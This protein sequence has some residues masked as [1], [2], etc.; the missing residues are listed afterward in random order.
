MSENQF[1]LT[2]QKGPQPGKVY[3][4]LT[5]AVTI[6]RDPMADIS[7][8]DP[9][10]SRQH[11]RLTRTASGYVVE[12]MGSTNGT[13][14]DGEKLDADTPLS[15]T[16]GQTISMGSGVTVL[17]Q[18][19]AP[20]EP[21]A[22][23]PVWADESF[24]AF[25]PDLYEPEELETADSSFP[26]IEDE[27]DDT[28]SDVKIYHVLGDVSQRRP[29]HFPMVNEQSTAK[30]FEVISTVPAKKALFVEAELEEAVAEVA[31]VDFEETDDGILVA[32]LEEEPETEYEM[33]EDDWLPFD[34]D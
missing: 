4:L 14:I 6:G 23:E 25:A 5:D 26:F 1:Q 24:D 28:L 3:L 11:L 22:S 34:D 20:E 31:V 30:P 17:Y 13:F 8:N 18:T 19:P 16:G 21:A 29:Y 33:F 27:P 2:V 32:D 15:L 7:L 10:V 9:E 12:D